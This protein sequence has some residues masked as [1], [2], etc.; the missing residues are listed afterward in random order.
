[1]INVYSKLVSFSSL[2]KI[3]YSNKMQQGQIDLH[4]WQKM[5]NFS[6]QWNLNFK[7]WQ[8]ATLR[9]ISKYSMALKIK[10]ASHFVL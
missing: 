7:F 10:E 1:M 3:V 2:N 8:E 4:V 9:I 5:P 6:V